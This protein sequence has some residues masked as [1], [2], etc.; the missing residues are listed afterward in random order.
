MPEP[1]NRDILP[2]LR[3]LPPV[4]QIVI[5]LDGR[6]RLAALALRPAGPPEGAARRSWAPWAEG[7]APA[8]GC[9]GL[10]FNNLPVWGR[11]YLVLRGG[12]PHSSGRR[13][14]LLP[15]Q[16]G[17]DRRGRGHG[18]GLGRRT[19]RGRQLG[20]LL[21][22]LFCGVGLFSLTLADLFEKVVAID[23]DEGACRDCAN[24]VQRDAAGP[25]QGHRAPRP[26]GPVLDRPDLAPA[27]DWQTGLCLV[28]PPRTGLGK[29]GVAALLGP[30]A[31][32][33]HLHELRPGHP[34]PRRGPAG[35]GRLPPRRLKVLDM[36]PQTAHIE[37][38]LLLERND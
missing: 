21:G 5:R 32:A 2:W 15:G 20:P 35:R 24:N 33:H 37:T 28:D 19:G 8:P 4:E 34:G 27:A 18:P 6:G 22:D 25:G 12:R 17:G 31:P 36:F 3:M 9:V 14:E 10:L 30:P 16:P 26:R 1:F 7:E 11:D 23:S 29:E 13:P 38:L